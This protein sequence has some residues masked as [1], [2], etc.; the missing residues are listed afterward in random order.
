MDSIAAMQARGAFDP[1]PLDGATL[2]TGDVQLL[3]P[4]G[5]APLDPD[6]MAKTALVVDDA[7]SELLAAC[8]IV[9]PQPTAKGISDVPP[10]KSTHAVKVT[11]VLIRHFVQ[12]ETGETAAAA[13]LRSSSVLS[14]TTTTTT[15]LP[16]A[17]VGPEVVVTL[18]AP[19]GPD[20]R[21]STALW[22]GAL[23]GLYVLYAEV[24]ADAESIA[25]WGDALVTALRPTTASHPIRWRAPTGLA[26]S[27]NAFG[28]W[29]IQ[30]PE[31]VGAVSK[32]FDDV[33]GDTKDPLDP[34]DA[35]AFATFRDESSFA[36]AGS[37]YVVKLLAPFAETPAQ[38]AHLASDVRHVS[39]AEEKTIGSPVG[40]I[41]R[42]DGDNAR[43]DHEVHAAFVSS[44]GEATVLH[45]V[46]AKEKWAAYAPL[47]DASLGSIE[48][49][50]T[51]D[52][53]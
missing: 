1:P 5:C 9:I 30:L 28:P 43:G 8:N 13:L 41:A 23:D 35:S 19:W 4:R 53:Y 36:F 17:N 2:A 37:A 32:T 26:P 16:G 45:F 7:E 40:S 48:R 10:S 18:N 31:K 39:I 22:Y 51:N 6:G 14:A 25:A 34:R 46:V 27:K 50:T 44:T 29:K 33:V 3:L 12:V 21:P 42:V 52:P 24:D 20:A 47:V 49:S 38:I 15:P 11:L